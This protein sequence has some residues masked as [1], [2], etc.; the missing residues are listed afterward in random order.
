M[1]DVHSP[2][3]LVPVRL[4]LRLARS[5]CQSTQTNDPAADIRRFL[6]RVGLQEIEGED[7]G[8]LERSLEAAGVGTIYD[9]EN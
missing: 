9:E 8:E 3:F 2:N 7:L 5:V 6:D 4:A 1:R